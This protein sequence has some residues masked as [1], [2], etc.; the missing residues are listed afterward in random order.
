MDSLKK[1]ICLLGSFAVGKTSLIERFVYDRFDDKYLTTIGVKV[2]LKNLSPIQSTNSGDF[3]RF[4]LLIWDISNMEK[5]DCAMASYFRG[6]AGALAVSDLSRPETIPELQEI[7]RKFLSVSPKA[8]IEV[9]GNKVD[10]FDKDHNTLNLLGKVASL[11][12]TKPLLT[13][14]KTG[15]TVETAFLMLARK[16]ASHEESFA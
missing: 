12:G 3:I 14:A 16:M 5:F 15:E 1:K 8:L 9:I 11:Y 6:S 4:S 2:S 7:C 10:I 13:S